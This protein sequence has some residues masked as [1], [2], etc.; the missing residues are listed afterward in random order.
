MNIENINRTAGTDWTTS[1]A[2]SKTQGTANADRSSFEASETIARAFKENLDIRPEKVAMA[3]QL[4]N[5]SA[6]PSPSIIQSVSQLLA[7]KL[8]S[9]A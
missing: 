5:A 7:E 6:Y 4:L 9:P 2:G 1:K 8:A 3:R